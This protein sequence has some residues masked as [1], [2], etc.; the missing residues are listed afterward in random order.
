VSRKAIKI[1]TGR[2]K[3]PGIVAAIA[4]ELRHAAGADHA[5]DDEAHG[6]ACGGTRHGL[7]GA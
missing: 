4:H 5:G 2:R 6:I 1:R 3:P 7:S